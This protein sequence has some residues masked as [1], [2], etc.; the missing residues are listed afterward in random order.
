M[1][2]FLSY[3]HWHLDS[4]WTLRTWPSHRGAISW[5]TSVANCQMAHFAN[6]AKATK[7]STCLPSNPSRLRTM[8]FVGYAS[9]YRKLCSN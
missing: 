8:R 5:P 4:C 7:K 1:S 9:H 6:S 2:F 3:S